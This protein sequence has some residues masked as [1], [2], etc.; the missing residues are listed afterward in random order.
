MNADGER[1]EIKVLVKFPPPVR[2][3][4]LP[5]FRG[6][7]PFDLVLDSARPNVLYAID[8]GLSK[9]V[10]VDT[11][12]GQAPDFVTF[13]KLPNPNPILGPRRIDPLPTGARQQGNWLYVAFLTGFPFP[14]G[15]AQI[16]RIDL[17]TGTD[18][19]F[20]DRLTSC[21]DVEP[22]G[23]TLFVLQLSTNL[24]A[25]PP[26]LPAPGRL[27]RFDP[28]TAGGGA[29]IADGLNLSNSM[30]RNPLTREFFIVEIGAGRVI[31]VMGQ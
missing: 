19:T 5:G 11:S 14:Q 16:H 26:R 25:I 10:K 6:S 7:D 17:D 31:R 8:G 15:A 21:V 23:D 22:V 2:D 12:T 29:V 20:L 1:A 9:V 24:L 4:S 28:G 27:L 3:S 30:A 18:Q 13:A